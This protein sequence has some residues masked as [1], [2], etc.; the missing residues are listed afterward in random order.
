MSS[1]DVEM[2]RNNSYAGN[3]R[4]KEEPADGGSGANVNNEGGTPNNG[5]QE[6]TRQSSLQKILQRKARVSVYFV[7]VS[8]LKYIISEL[9]L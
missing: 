7:V 8:I 4:I 2:E 5:P 9:L 1:N 6:A 3:V